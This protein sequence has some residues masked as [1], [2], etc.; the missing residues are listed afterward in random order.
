MVTES[1]MD[2]N[3]INLT[4]YV[5]KLA[6]FCQEAVGLTGAAAAAALQAGADR[7]RKELQANLQALIRKQIAEGRP[8]EEWTA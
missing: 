5:A 6:I 4:I 3:I 8:M 7:V 2:I 1:H